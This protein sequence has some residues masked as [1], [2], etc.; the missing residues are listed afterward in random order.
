MAFTSDP[1]TDIGKVRLL[2]SDT[3]AANPIFPDDNQIQAF[4]QIEAQ[5][6]RLAAALGLETIASN[7]LMVL[8]AIKV[9]DIQT[10]GSKVAKGMLEIAKQYRDTAASDWAGFD[11]AV[12]TDESVFAFR[13]YLWRMYIQQGSF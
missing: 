12:A 10:D 2:I 9:L 1:A 6:P 13:E 3:D 5:D 7:Q 8:K 4:L 11:I